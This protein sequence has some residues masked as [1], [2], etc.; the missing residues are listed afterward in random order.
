MDRPLFVEGKK[1]ALGGGG[2]PAAV[3]NSSN[4]RDSGWIEIKNNT[5]SAKPRLQ[6][7]C[8]IYNDSTEISRILYLIFRVKTFD[9]LLE[10]RMWKLGEAMGFTPRPMYSVCLKHFKITSM[11][12]TIYSRVLIMRSSVVPTFLFIRRSVCQNA[13]LHLSA[14]MLKLSLYFI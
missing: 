9:L 1:Y 5:H 14:L 3:M 12:I 4:A 13:V 2:V 11:A 7:V 6:L 8:E 10:G